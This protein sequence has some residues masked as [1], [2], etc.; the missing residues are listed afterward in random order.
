MTAERSKYICTDCAR[1]MSSE[2]IRLTCLLL[3]VYTLY[4][5]LWAFVGG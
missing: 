1:R 2:A 4:H 3:V 5:E